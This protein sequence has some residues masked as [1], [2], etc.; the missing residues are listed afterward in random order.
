[1]E[2]IEAD[3]TLESTATGDGEA[4]GPR[5][6]L[7]G[8]ATPALSSSRSLSATASVVRGHRKN[9]F[10][11]T[12]DVAGAAYVRTPGSGAYATSTLPAPLLKVLWPARTKGKRRFLVLA[13]LRLIP[14]NLL[15]YRLD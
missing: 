12:Y 5:T 8:S 6:L 4:D 14:A 15:E 7:M 1:M 2:A 10:N 13:I 11:A 9:I 3:R